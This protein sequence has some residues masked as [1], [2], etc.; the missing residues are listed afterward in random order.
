[1]QALIWHQTLQ[2]VFRALPQ[3]LKT[4]AKNNGQKQCQK[5]WPDDASG[6]PFFFERHV[7]TRSRGFALTQMQQPV[8]ALVYRL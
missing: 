6:S 3:W 1:M 8:T 5:A 2:P 7:I 4:M